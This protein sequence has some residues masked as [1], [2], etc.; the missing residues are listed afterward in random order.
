M[1][2]T[3]SASWHLQVSASWYLHVSASCYLHVSASW[4]L[5]VSASWYLQVSA[6]PATLV[7]FLCWSHTSVL[8]HIMNLLGRLLEQNLNFSQGLSIFSNTLEQ[9][10]TLDYDLRP[11]YTAQFSQQLV[12]QC[13]CFVVRSV[14]RRRTQLHFSQRNAATGNTIAQC[15]TP[16]VTL[17]AILWQFYQERMRTL[18]VFRSEE[19]KPSLT[20]PKILQ[21]V[22]IAF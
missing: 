15:I 13:R 10:T 21:V 17:L 11:C 19:L 7:P 9:N 18:L 2:F 12:S 16:P 3:V 5:H 20:P 8:S 6:S 1:A 14:A 4:Y 22:E